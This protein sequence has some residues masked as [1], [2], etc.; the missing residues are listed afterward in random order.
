MVLG[1]A[2]IGFRFIVRFSRSRS[3]QGS[4]RSARDPSTGYEPQSD[5][6]CLIQFVGTLGRFH[7]LAP[8]PPHS[9]NLLRVS[10]VCGFVTGLS[11]I[12]SGRD[13]DKMAKHFR[14]MAL[15]RKTGS[16]AHFEH[17]HI[18]TPKKLLSA[19]DSPSDNLSM[20]TDSHTLLEQASEI[21]KVHSSHR[22]QYRKR[23]TIM[24][25]WLQCTPKRGSA[26]P[27]ASHRGG[28]L[29]VE[30]KSNIPISPCFPT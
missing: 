18:R 28:D 7:R 20:R 25:G 12:F 23:Q 1:C 17:R 10:P 3:V 29:A 24:K 22:R 13:P 16:D 27:W 5:A 26:A 30:E 6:H 8:K 15:I 19:S 9:R 2:A 11:A 21:V 4:Q 14:K